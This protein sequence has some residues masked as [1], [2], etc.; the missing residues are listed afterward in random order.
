MALRVVIVDDEFPARQELRC[1]FEE[2]TNIVIVGECK[3][4]EEA[5]ALAGSQE[6]DAIFLDVHMR[7][8]DEGLAIAAKIKRLPRPPKIV[9]TTGFSEFAV[10]AFELNAVDYVLKPYSK[11]RLELTVE[12]LTRDEAEPDSFFLDK[13]PDPVRMPVWHNDRLLVLQPEEIF[14]VKSEQ[15]R[16]AVLCTTKGDFI[17]NM[18]LKQIQQRLERSGFLRTH[19][20]YLVNISKVREIVPWFNNTYVLV[21]D[22]CP[23]EDIPV[24]KHYIKEFNQAMGI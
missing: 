14:F 6:V 1:I 19:K 15:K 7:T 5:Y 17:S 2:I 20:S 9:F 10:K 12:R 18:A 3:N 24:A 4:G 11:E 16:K 23:V 21:L 13:T 8:P 22:G